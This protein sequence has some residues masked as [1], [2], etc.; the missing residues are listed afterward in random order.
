ML[1]KVL[2]LRYTITH[3]VLGS[4]PSE[5]MTFWPLPVRS[6]VATR[7]LFGLGTGT[8]VESIGS[9][10]F[11]ATDGFGALISSLLRSG[12]AVRPIYLVFGDIFP[13][14]TDVSGGE[15]QGCE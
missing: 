6:D 9:L 2:V 15:L 8:V 1:N 11:S 13:A 5:S 10:T 14:M 12:D 4:K 7:R 3:A